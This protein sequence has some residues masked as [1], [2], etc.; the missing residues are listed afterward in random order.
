[1]VFPLAASEWRVGATTCTLSATEDQHLA[2]TVQGRD[3]LY[4]PLWFDLQPRRLKRKRT[5]RQLTIGDQLRIV[6][7]DQA[8]GYRIQVGPEQWM[9]YR[10]LAGHSGRTV[11]GKHLVE[12][13]YCSRFDPGDGSH[14]ELITVDDSESS[15]D[16]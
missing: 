13:F 6:G 5:W 16:G 11:L 10:S 1:M 9:V 12:D 4:A 8:A 7:T 15:D 14:E 3:R 2:I